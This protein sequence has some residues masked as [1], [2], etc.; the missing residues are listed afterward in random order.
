MKYVLILACAAALATP[1]ANAQNALDPF[2][3][4][5]SADANGDGAVDKAEFL[6]RR[7]QTFPQIDANADGALTKDEFLAQ[8][9]S[10]Q[11]RF[12]ASSLFSTF[13]AN[14]D[15]KVSKQEFETAPSPLF[16]RADGNKD[17]V[18]TKAELDAVRP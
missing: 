11:A 10:F 18:V 4:F 6:A 8:A 3:L 2:A 9:G 5:A 14:G 7:A 17:G 1:L 15:G 13:D 16:D 12:T